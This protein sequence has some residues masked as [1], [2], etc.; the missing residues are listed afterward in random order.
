HA[1]GRAHVVHQGCDQLLLHFLY[2]AHELVDGGERGVLDDARDDV[3]GEC[4]A[5]Q[6]FVEEVRHHV[7]EQGVL[8]HQ[9]A[10]V[11]VLQSGPLAAVPG[12]GGA[13]A[14]EDVDV[15]G[16]GVGPQRDQRLHNVVEQI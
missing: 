8:V 12:R 15:G 10:D 4:V 6:V 3:G 2:G 1:Q 14:A 7:A 9:V 16:D 13:Q 11:V 5:G